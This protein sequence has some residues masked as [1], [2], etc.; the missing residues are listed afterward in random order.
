[1]SPDVPAA[2]QQERVAALRAAVRRAVAAGD[3]TAARTLRAE[4]RAAEGGERLR[5]ERDR[6][7]VRA[8]AHRALELL[9]VPAGPKLVGAVHAAFFAAPIP[10]ARLGVLRRAEER[11]FRKAPNAR[12]FYV[13]AALT[14]DLLTPARGLLAVSTWPLERRV[15]GPLSRRTDFLTAAVRVAEHAQHAD[16]AQHLLR[17]FAAGIPGAAGGAVGTVDPADLIAAARAELDVHA[18]ADRRDRARAA[19]RAAGLDAAERL[20]G[21][22]HDRTG[23][24][25]GERR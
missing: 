10:A 11:A 20:F 7:D 12:P 23:R 6:A 2:A 18:T 4:L 25:H 24:P 16:A 5:A 3:R 21:S 8:Q 13:C 9:G 14:A 15:V 1:M 17:R 22:A 19:R